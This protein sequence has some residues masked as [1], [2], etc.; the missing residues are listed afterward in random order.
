[1]AGIALAESGGNPKAYNASGATGLWQVEW[2]LHKGIPGA[3]SQAQLF[4]ADGN[5]VAAAYLY[6]G[7]PGISNWQ[8]DKIYNA[9][10]KAGRPHDPSANTVNKWIAE[11]LYGMTSPISGAGAAPGAFSG[12]TPE[13][14]SASGG[15]SGGGSGGLTGISAG[16][17][18]WVSRALMVAGGL[19]ALLLGIYLLINSTSMGSGIASSV[20]GGA[21]GMLLT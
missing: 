11:D 9:W 14:P 7:G 10:V 18:S 3:S 1:M 12:A 21:K 5:A 2:P 19:A 20:K 6:G 15:G 13:G 16:V 17:S 4:T 8:G